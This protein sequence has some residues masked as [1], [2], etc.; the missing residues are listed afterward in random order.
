MSGAV[1][2]WHLKYGGREVGFICNNWVYFTLNHNTVYAILWGF[3]RVR[4]QEN[5][6]E[7]SIMLQA[8]IIRRY[9]RCPETL[10]VSYPRVEKFLHT[11]MVESIHNPASRD[12]FYS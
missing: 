4:V 8:S 11:V 10:C 9:R 6:L 12:Y 2:S 5:V 1:F 7:R 3:N